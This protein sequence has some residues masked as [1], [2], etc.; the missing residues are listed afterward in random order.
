[1][2]PQVVISRAGYVIRAVGVNKKWVPVDIAG[3]GVHPRPLHQTIADD[4]SAIVIAG[5]LGRTAGII[6][7][8][9]IIPENTIGDGNGAAVVINAP[10][11]GVRVERSGIATKADL[12]QLHPLTEHI[13]QATA[14]K[15]GMVTT[16]DNINQ[17]QAA[18][19]V[20]YAA[21]HKSGR[22]ASK[23]KVVQP[24]VALSIV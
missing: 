12:G 3:A 18:L 5:Q 23:D 8:I 7:T 9:T 20:G 22:I 24:G 11:F 6:C 21:P 2:Q 15:F 10:A 13:I 4:E 14:S 19:D 16:E 1:M 17:R